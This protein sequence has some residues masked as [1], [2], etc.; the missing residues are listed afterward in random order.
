MRSR[1]RKGGRK[2]V[3]KGVRRGVHPDTIFTS[4]HLHRRVFRNLPDSFFRMG[5][6][7]P[8]KTG[9]IPEPGRPGTGR[10]Q[11]ISED[12][13]IGR[14]RKPED[15]RKAQVQIERTQITNP[16]KFRALIPELI[17]AKILQPHEEREAWSIRVRALDKSTDP[18]R[19][20][21]H[22]ALQS[23]CDRNL[24]SDEEREGAAEFK[25]A[26]PERIRSIW[27]REHETDRTEGRISFREFCAGELGEAADEMSTDEVISRL[28]AKSGA[29]NWEKHLPPEL[30]RKLAKV[31][32]M[33]AAGTWPVSRAENRP[34]NDE[35]L[36][37]LRVLK[38][39]K[40]REVVERPVGD[41]DG[42]RDDSASK[43]TCEAPERA[44]GR[45]AS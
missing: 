13:L 7:R 9:K 40:S 17:A 36:R 3:R 43:G 18:H 32:A 2:G 38:E 23:P 16:T 25:A 37:R 39:E 42:V 31:D 8:E 24:T 35:R 41:A 33:K 1:V 20:F 29:E 10:F 14:F 19:L 28:E 27:S 22:V 12:V 30:Q 15:P 45:E 6:K 26:H 21:M 5:G 11:K 44:E 34:S 4:L